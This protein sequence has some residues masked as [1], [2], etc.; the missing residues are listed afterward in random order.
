MAEFTGAS[1]LLSLVCVAGYLYSDSLLMLNLA[2][3]FFV[4]MIPLGS[5]LRPVRESNRKKLTYFTT[6]IIGVGLLGIFIN[7][8]MLITIAFVGL[9]IY[10]F[11]INGILIRENARVFE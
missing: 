2:L 7:N 3:A 4:F 1:L 11:V 8:S 6:G 9:F 10:Q 5:F